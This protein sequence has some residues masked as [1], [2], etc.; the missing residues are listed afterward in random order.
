MTSVSVDCESA[1]VNFKS[2]VIPGVAFICLIAVF[3]ALPTVARSITPDLEQD[4]WK[5]LAFPGKIETRFVG[6]ADGIIEVKSKNSV[7]LLYRRVP[8]VLERSR[9]LSWRWRVD[10]SMPP[11]DL[12]RKGSDDRPIALHVWFP[13]DSERTSWWRRLYSRVVSSV[14]D[15]SLPGKVLTYVWGG[16]GRRGDRLVNPH[17]GP[18]AMMYILR[19]GDAPTGRWFDEKVDFVTDF[20]MA[21]GYPAP[22]PSYIAISGD[23][24]DTNSAS[25]A[26]IAGILFGDD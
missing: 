18:R 13:R 22:R 6:R 7:A 1:I 21:F 8:P 20:E 23:A 16:T 11:T 24:D 19:S 3:F 2:L 10:E 14:V 17:T 26:L 12:A 25:E 5:V 4:G 9:Y 15:V